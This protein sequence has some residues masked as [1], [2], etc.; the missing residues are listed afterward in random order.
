MSVVIP[1]WTTDERVD[2]KDRASELCQLK[3]QN[4]S[5]QIEGIPSPVEANFS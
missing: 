3:R 1:D 2:R 5:E 4:V